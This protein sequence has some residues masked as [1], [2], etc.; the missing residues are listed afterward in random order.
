MFNYSF[1]S[2]FVSIFLFSF[3]FSFSISSSFPFLFLQASGGWPEDEEAPSAILGRIEGDF[4]ASVVEKVMVFAFRLAAAELCGGSP[5]G[6]VP[7]PP[8]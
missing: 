7:T 8:T 4:G 3:S 1:Y 5:F 6:G 2:F